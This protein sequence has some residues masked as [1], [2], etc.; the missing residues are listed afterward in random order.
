MMN[1]PNLDAM[2]IAAAGLLVALAG[3]GQSPAEVAA[4]QQ[5][6]VAP[7]AQPSVSGTG[8]VLFAGPS[9]VISDYRCTGTMNPTKVTFTVKPNMLKTL[10]NASQHIE[11]EVETVTGGTETP[12]PKP[13]ANI[14]KKYAPTYLDMGVPA[15]GYEGMWTQITIR[16]RN[17]NADN[18]RFMPVRDAQGNESKTDSSFAVLAETGNVGK[19]CGREEFGTDGT[20]HDVVRFGVKLAKDET[21][22]IN[23][24]LLIEDKKNKDYWIPIYLDPNIKNVG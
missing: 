23:I 15:P 20:G 4:G 8:S 19:F 6:A 2:H 9:A 1:R 10:G 13:P 18:I 22:S 21:V 16:L 12:Q 11:R 14:A 3:C 7:V 17:R 24:G 5:T